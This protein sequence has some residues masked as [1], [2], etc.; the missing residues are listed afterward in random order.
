[1]PW[2]HH[3][4]NAFGSDKFIYLAA[5][6]AL[7]TVSLL[8]RS[9]IRPLASYQLTEET[10]GEVELTSSAVRLVLTGSRGLRWLPVE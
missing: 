7:F 1:M 8:H 2:L 9:Y 6:F 10:R 3:F 4:N 5:I